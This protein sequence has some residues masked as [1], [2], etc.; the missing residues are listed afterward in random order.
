MARYSSIIARHRRQVAP[1]YRKPAYSHLG[2]QFQP[3]KSHAR[4]T[5]QVLDAKKFLRQHYVDKPSLSENEKFINART[6]NQLCELADN[7]PQVRYF[8]GKHPYIA[9]WLMNQGD[10]NERDEVIACLR[11]TPVP[12]L[13]EK[14]ESLTSAL[15]SMTLIPASPTRMQTNLLEI[16]QA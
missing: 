10:I 12:V 11:S 7:D 2:S 9:T 16:E 3:M 8:L 15:S 5:V 13:E 4:P 1:S 14:L 6:I